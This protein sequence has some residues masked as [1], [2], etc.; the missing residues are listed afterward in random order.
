MKKVLVVLL[1][2]T[3]LAAALCISV[4]ADNVSD[5]MDYAH[6]LDGSNQVPGDVY[7]MV[8]NILRQVPVSADQANELK[9]VLDDV[10]AA[11]PTYKGIGAEE[12]TA[13]E[14][15]AVLNAVDEA[16]EILRVTTNVEMKSRDDIVVNVTYNQ[17]QVGAIDFDGIRETGASFENT[18]LAIA[19]IVSVLGAA[20]LVTVALKKKAYE[21]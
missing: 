3:L 18:A 10:K 19:S 21:N 16:S 8:E 7:N 1:T 12:Y 17:Q 20:V 4:S 2:A 15:D 6:S 9:G 14:V 11:V 5:V 13:A